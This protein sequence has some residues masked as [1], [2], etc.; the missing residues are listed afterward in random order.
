MSSF[1]VVLHYQKEK[2]EKEEVT[3]ASR[4]SRE[5]VSVRETER[6]KG[7]NGSISLHFTVIIIVCWVLGVELC[8]FFGLSIDSLMREREHFIWFF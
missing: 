3:R 6:E 2:E 5:C 1:C 7:E 8:C 4:E